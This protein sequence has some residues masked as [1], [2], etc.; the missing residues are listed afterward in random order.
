MVGPLLGGVFT[1]KVSW[2]WCFYLNLPIG[3]V[4]LIVLAFLLEMPQHQRENL[5]FR[6][7]LAKL[8]LVGTFF[9]IPGV[10]SFLLA[11]QVSD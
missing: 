6:Q 2:R 11:L 7:Q 8:D 5:T 4:A 10:V 9:F 1:D 3:A